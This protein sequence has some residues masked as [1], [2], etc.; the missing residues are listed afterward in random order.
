[1]IIPKSL[2]NPSSESRVR[3]RAE[4]FGTDATAFTVI[5]TADPLLLVSRNKRAYRSSI[6]TESRR[7]TFLSPRQV[8]RLS[9][10]NVR[11]ITSTSPSKFTLSAIY[12]RSRYLVVTLVAPTNAGG[13]DNRVKIPGEGVGPSRHQ[14]VRYSFR[15]QPRISIIG[16][17]NRG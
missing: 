10:L 5:V 2:G 13:V 7:K 9:Q 1:M 6:R 16:V 8:S 15:I 3:S 14:I 12:S 4:M 11:V 17:T